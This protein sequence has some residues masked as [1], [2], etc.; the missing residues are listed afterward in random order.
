M[1]E[2]KLECPNCHRTDFIKVW[3]EEVRNSLVF[4][5]ARELIPT[6]LKSS[7]EWGKYAK[8]E[9]GMVDCPHCGKTT[10]YE[11]ISAY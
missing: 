3:N 7:D 11:D 5:R 4:K 9:Q 10:L 1:S 2:L 6:T 8:K